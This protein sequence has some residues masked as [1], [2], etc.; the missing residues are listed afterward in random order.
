[1]LK[2][3]VTLKIINR[4]FKVLMAVTVKNAVL[5]CAAPCGGHDRSVGV[6]TRCGMDGSVI[7]ADRLLGLRVR[8]PSGGMDFCVVC[9]KCR[10]KGKMQDNQDKHVRLKHTQS[11]GKY[12]K[13]N[14]FGVTFSAPFHT[15]C[16][17]HPASYKMGTG[18]LSRA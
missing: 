4:R 2:F 18:S 1:M 5:P 12:K 8:I 9:C 17:A 14:P 7:A 10:Q 6:A 11:T 16:G 3:K 15:G 13:R